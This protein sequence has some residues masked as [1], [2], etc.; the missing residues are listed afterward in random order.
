MKLKEEKREKNEIGQKENYLYIKFP[1]RPKNER[2]ARMIAAAFLADMNPNLEE[3]DD[4]KTAV[5]EAVTNSIIHA[6]EKK[7]LHEKEEI[8]MMKRKNLKK[9]EKK[10]KWRWSLYRRDRLCLSQLQIKEREL[11]ISN[12]LWNLF[13]RQNRMKNVRE[14][15][16]RLWKLL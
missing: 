11:K 10:M 5:S 7:N 3:L 16:F 9:I 1:A 12:R 13:L 6:Y 15:D 2:L 8:Q 4:V 14:W